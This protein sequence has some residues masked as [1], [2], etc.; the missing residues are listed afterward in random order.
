MVYRTNI[1]NNDQISA[2][3]LGCMR[4][5]KD[6]AA[7]SAMIA[8]AIECGVNY[9]DTAYV[10]PNSEERLGNALAAGN[11]RDK[12]KIATKLPPYLASKYEDFDKIFTKQ[13][14]RL[15]TD[16]IDYYMIHM[17]TELKSWQ[18]L[19]ELGILK[20]L[21]AKKAAGA[22]INFG[23]SYHGGK[24]EF[25]R[26]IDAYDWDFCM[27]QYNYLDEFNQAGKSGLNY[28]RG[29]GVPVIVMEPLRGGALAGKL[30]KDALDCIK[31][32]YVKRS[33]A[34]WGF[35]W[36]FNHPVLT[37]LSGMNTIEMIDENIRVAGE[38]PP[39]SL[40]DKDF[41]VY[42][43]IIAHINAKTLVGCTGCNYCM[44]CPFE[45]DIPLCFS[46]LNETMILNQKMVKFRYILRTDKHNAG[47]CA[48]CGKCEN[49]CPQGIKIRQELKTAQ[50]VMEGGLYRP[51]RF[52]LRKVM[53]F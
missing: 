8:H 22:I 42:K 31:G 20:W 47:L 49:L 37:V 3:G 18:R 30:P 40:T 17:L 48:G 5:P 1:K 34:E 53:K 28:A 51:L 33:P 7:L 45:V 43:Q 52:L 10:Y 24:G 4:F 38:T 9:F 11:F 46:C 2:L 41:E 44:P 50:K 29:K 27:I 6:N 26:I 12:I 14:T 39:G 13:L 35:K 21:E 16:R 32:A 15:K 19:L 25:E 23:F 36:V